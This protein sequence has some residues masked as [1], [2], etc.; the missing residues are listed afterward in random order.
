MRNKKPVEVLIVSGKGGTGK[1]SITA[2]FAYFLE[3]LIV[4]D[5]DV[6]TPNLSFLIGAEKTPFFNEPFFG[7][8]KARLI[9]DKCTSCGA[10]LNVC[11]FGAISRNEKTGGPLFDPILCEGCGVCKIVCEYD[12]IELL[13]KE[14]GRILGTKSRFGPFV[15]GKL[16]PGEGNSGRLVTLVRNKAFEIAEKESKEIV[17]IDGPPGIGCPVISAMTGVGYVVVVT[18]CSISGRR[19]LERI[20]ELIK[21]FKIKAGV[22][23]NKADIDNKTT[24]LIRETCGLF[25]VPVLGLVPFD[26][27]FVDALSEGIPYL[28]LKERK[29]MYT[30]LTSIFNN[31]KTSILKP[32]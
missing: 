2:S 11:R 20:L 28:E 22:I 13:D 7:E 18:E 31:L 30:T 29:G 32:S 27:D 9:E 26:P 17:L 24:E 25:D 5:C 6:D 8:R 19:D 15:F 21:H 14:S 23:I 16:Y 4:A 1:T 12:A 3:D 10:C